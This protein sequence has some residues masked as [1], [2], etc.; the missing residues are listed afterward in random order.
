[1]YIVLEVFPFWFSQTSGASCA[2]L[3]AA[4]HQD[5]GISKAFSFCY[6]EMDSTKQAAGA[7]NKALPEEVWIKVGGKPLLFSLLS[8][9]FQ[10][11]SFSE[12]VFFLE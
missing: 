10:I 1:M 6:Q 12:F 3:E 11:Y 8:F 2:M 4:K 5:L 7:M 9:G